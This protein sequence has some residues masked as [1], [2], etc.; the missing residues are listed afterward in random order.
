MQTFT[1]PLV[2]SFDHFILFFNANISDIPYYRTADG[3]I[4]SYSNHAYIAEDWVSNEG[5]DIV[6]TDSAYAP[7]STASS[8]S[9]ATDCVIIVGVYGF[10]SSEY[11]VT[12]TSSSGA[13][14][15]Q[16]GKVRYDSVAHQQYK[17][18]RVLVS[19]AGALE[20]YTLRFAVVPTSG[21]VHLYVSCD[22]FQPNATNYQWSLAPTSGSG[23]YIDVLSLVAAEKGCLHSGSQYYAS[24]FGDTAS[25]F[26]ISAAINGA[27]NVPMLIPGETHSA[28]VAFQ[29]VDYY[30]VRPGDVYQ[31]VRL[32]AT[33]LQGDVD[34]Y[35]SM[36][37]S[38]RPTVDPNTGEVKSYV[39]SSSK[40]GSEDMT[41]PHHWIEN[42][43]SKMENCYFIVA[44]V[45]AGSQSSYTI[46]AAT[47]DSTIAL[48]AGVPRQSHVDAGKLEYFKFTITQPD[49]DVVISVTPISG[50]PDMFIS[51]APVK[52]PSR[53]NN[54]WFQ[55][56]FGADSL[57]LQYTDT[58][59]H[60]VPNPAVSG[61]HCDVFIGVYGWQNT[62]FTILAN[63]DEGFRAPSTL[64]DQVPQ[65]G[66]VG[67]SQY[68]YYKYAVSVPHTGGASSP[69][70]DIKFSLTPTDDGDADLFLLI[71]P[72]GNKTEPGV[73]SS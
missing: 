28:Q 19:Q 36:S 53:T 17:N 56:K 32:L 42:S 40:S 69:A 71:E 23:S 31:D 14:L 22:T 58:S 39:L 27:D 38:T 61:K 2:S 18:F 46:L 13:T 11:T 67:T 37:W 1:S 3:S 50:D 34:I 10:S 21:H 5:L 15:L 43:C 45:G 4:P 9:G 68:T 7:C 64:L 51:M 35:V 49:L 70:L 52:H 33:V 55:S 73:V 8:G 16:L 47:P 44:V 30:F 24:V 20:P 12:L 62:T 26:S 41:I 57:T 66:Y 60:C 48:S 29:Q 63:V 54:T 72:K 59:K 25:T 6:H 65:T